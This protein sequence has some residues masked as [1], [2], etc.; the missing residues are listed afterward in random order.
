MWVRHWAIHWEIG[1]V[2]DW[3]PPM[4]PRWQARSENQWDW[5]LGIESN[6]DQTHHCPRD[7]SHGPATFESSSFATGSHHSIVDGTFDAAHP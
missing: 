5:A 2:W 7:P 3:E 6:R 4:V 1:W